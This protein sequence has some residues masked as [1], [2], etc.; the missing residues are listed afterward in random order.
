M[1]YRNQNA[2]INTENITKLHMGHYERRQCWKWYLF[3]YPKK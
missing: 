2:Y 1:N 3:K